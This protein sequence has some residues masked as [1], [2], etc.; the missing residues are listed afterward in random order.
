MKDQVFKSIGYALLYS[1]N[2]VA[3]LRLATVAGEVH[4][5]WSL[6]IAEQFYLFWPLILLA[7]LRLKL[8]RRWL[9]IVTAIVVA[10]VCLYRMMLVSNGASIVRV[11]EGSDTRA[12]S[13]LIG[14]AAAML[15]TWN[16][17]GPA[18]KRALPWLCVLALLVIALFITAHIPDGFLQEAGFTIFALA[19]GVVLLHVVHKPLR[20][21]ERLFESR[22][23]VWLGKVSYAL[24]LWQIFAMSLV[25]HRPLSGFAK[26]SL[27][28]ALTI[29]LAAA[30][31]YLV[32]RPFLRLKRRFAPN[33][34]RGASHNSEQSNAQPTEPVSVTG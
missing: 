8:S 20:L 4:H 3:A 33:A 5:T 32:E 21:L 7:L 24:Y 6:A 14:C 18:I 2:W 25:E 30:S 31:F 22:I 10:A 9:V 1:T 26:I 23:L 12:D 11:Y 17:I 13:L 15:Y 19:V 29:G 28:V 16:M 27:S 34:V